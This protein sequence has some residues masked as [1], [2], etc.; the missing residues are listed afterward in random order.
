MQEQAPYVV[1]KGRALYLRP[2]LRELA[3][4]MLAWGSQHER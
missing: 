3:A 2:V 4:T 1:D